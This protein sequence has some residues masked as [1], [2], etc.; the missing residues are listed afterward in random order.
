MRILPGLCAL[1]VIATAACPE[2]LPSSRPLGVINVSD[3][4]D[5]TGAG[6]GY[7]VKPT[8]VFWQASNLPS[9]PYSAA[10]PDACIEKDYVPPDTTTASLTGQLDAG[11]PIQAQSSLATIDMKPDT[12]W[13]VPPPNPGSGLLPW[14]LIVYKGP[15]A[16][17]AHVPGGDIIFTVPGASGGYPS[18]VT[19]AVTAKKLILGPID[20]KP[21]DSLHLTWVAGS[22]GN[23]AAVNVQ[24]IYSKTSLTVP[25]RQLICS[26]RDDGDF[27]VGTNFASNWAAA[28]NWYQTANAFRWV[29]TYTTGPNNTLLLAIAEFDTTK[30]TFP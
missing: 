6:G 12:V 5:G 25:N 30:T 4:S 13:R 19:H 8:G 16:G 18:M 20:P 7:I 28:Y 10:A 23:V 27:W 21:T 14:K 11:S 1:L 9:L 15:T 17:F 26:M 29:T 2:S 24:L 3:T 22:A